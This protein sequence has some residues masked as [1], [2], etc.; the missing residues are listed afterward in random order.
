MLA[1]TAVD[2]PLSLWER[3]LLLTEITVGLLGQS[4]VMP[5]VSAYAHLSGSFDYNK[6]PLDLM[7]CAVQ[8]HE[9][10]DKQGMWA[11]HSVDR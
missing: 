5:A 6:I 4:N 9:E 7:G 11:Y 2:F 8:I 1:G 3:L 10:T